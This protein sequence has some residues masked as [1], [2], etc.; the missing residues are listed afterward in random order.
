MNRP[1]KP[2]AFIG[3]WLDDI[4]PGVHRRIKGLRLVTAYGIAALMGAVYDIAYTLPDGASLSLLAG[5]IALWASVSE[6]RATRA[7]S[8]RD[9]AMLAASAVLG[10]AFTAGLTPWLMHAGRAVPELTLV[11]GAFLV[12]YGKR[13]GLLGGGIGS[14]FFIG[15]LLAYSIGLTS[16]DFPLLIA[17]GVIAATAA[18]VPRVL[19][20]PAEHPTALPPAPEVVSFWRLSPEFVMGLQAALAA[21]VIVALN[22]AF[23]LTESAWAMAACTY[24]VTSTAAGTI[25]RIRQRV[26]GT[27]IGL[28]L[29]LAC[30]PVAEHAAILVWAAAAVAMVI[31]AMA[32]PQRYDIACAAYTFTLIVT[33]AASGEHSLSLLTARFWETLIGGAL[34]LAAATFIFPLR[35]RTTP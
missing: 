34:G 29:G 4:D 14:Q 26:I 6:G 16:S 3:R 33:L 10:G 22:G 1:W 17:A 31:Y 25:A 12:G 18:I 35:E 21:L 19:S 8:S 5:G 24:V 2:L 27:A 28:P 30:L 9:L 7:E 20:G 23:T 32:L 11:L 13:F 15:Q